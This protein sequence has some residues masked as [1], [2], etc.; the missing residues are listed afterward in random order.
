[1]YHTR[2]FSTETQNWGESEGL[3]FDANY[4]PL[5]PIATF[6]QTG[7]LANRISSY[8]NFIALQWIYGYQ[9]YLD[10]DFKNYIQSIFKNVTFPTFPINH[11]KIKNW[12]TVNHDKDFQDF[13]LFLKKSNACMMANRGVD[14]HSCLP[15]AFGRI[16]N[17]HMSTGHNAPRWEILAENLSGLK[18]HHLQFTDEIMEVVRQVLERV[19]AH[20]GSTLVGVH[21][22]RT[23]YV[24]FRQ[25]HT[26]LDPVN[27]T[28]F[29]AAMQFYRDKY[30]DTI[31]LVVS[32]DIGWCKE[33]ITGQ[34]VFHVEDGSPGSDLAIM[35]S[36]HHSII[37]Y[38]CYGVWEGSLGRG[39]GSH[40]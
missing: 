38:G 3:T 7:R 20:N 33:K 31:F 6:Q 32:D 27:E 26:G 14:K 30:P 8:A 9:L 24:E 2:E 4:C 10:E 29:Q 25:K 40:S 22:R 17:I 19:A 36:C 13:P 21:V 11:C 34:D 5:F 15:A 12:Y 16:L 23:D 28:Y 39:G 18:K 1:M 35:S 37:D